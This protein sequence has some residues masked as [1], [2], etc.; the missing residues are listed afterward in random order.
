M[1]CRVVKNHSW[2]SL[3][4]DSSSP[5]GP[6]FSTTWMLGIPMVLPPRGSGLKTILLPQDG[7][8][9]RLLFISEAKLESSFSG[10][11]EENEPINTFHGENRK[12]GLA[13]KYEGSQVPERA[14]LQAY[15]RG[16]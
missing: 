16:G 4:R 11:N 6:D 9:Q 12:A 1:L 13:V 15:E 2:L 8:K 7:R 5:V 3:R 14:I 10:G